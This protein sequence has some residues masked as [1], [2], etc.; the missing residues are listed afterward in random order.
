LTAA[1]PTAAIIY[2]SVGISR[3][4]TAAPAR[5]Q[6]SAVAWCLLAV[7][8][9]AADAATDFLAAFTTEKRTVADGLPQSNVR[10]LS[11]GPDGYL[12]VTT[13]EHMSRFD[14]V[15]FETVPPPAFDP[16]RAPLAG[17]GVGS[18][19]AL[20]LHGYRKVWRHDGRA[21]Q[22]LADEL[23]AG[24]PDSYEDVVRIAHHPDG[25]CW[26]LLR[27]GLVRW[28]PREPQ[29]SWLKP[30]T[31][32][33]TQWN[34]DLVID[35]S[36]RVW[37]ASSSGISRVEGRSLVAVP[38]TA[39]PAGHA[40][41]MRLCRRRAGGIWAYTASGLF[42]VDESG[43][44]LLAPYPG[45]PGAQQIC[46]AS[47]GSVWV[48]GDAGIQR[49]CG[50][51]WSSLQPGTVPGVTRFTTVA[52]SSSRTLW[53]GGDGGL[54][55]LRPR[56]HRLLPVPGGGSSRS[57]L[58][59]AAWHD[60][61]GATLVGTGNRIHQLDPASGVTESLALVPGTHQ[62]GAG[63][64]SALARD[65]DGSLWVGTGNEQLWCLTGDRWRHF[66]ADAGSPVPATG[67]TSILPWPGQL[68]FIGSVNGLMRIT[69]KL[70]MFPAHPSLP[71]DRVQCLV[72]DP[73][74][75][76]IWIGYESHGL[77]F[78]DPSSN[79][80]D[81]APALAGIPPGRVNAVLPQADG[82][83]W[84]SVGDALLWW[85]DGR[86]VARFDHHH[87]LPSGEV[88]LLAADPLGNIWLAEAGRLVCIPSEDL[89]AV[90]AG[91][92]SGVRLRHHGH[93]LP[94]DSSFGT[95]AGHPMS[96]PGVR[97]TV[98]DGII[99]A[100]GDMIPPPAPPPGVRIT[101]I[102]SRGQ[103]LADLSPV[104]PRSP[105]AQPVRVPPGTAPVDIEFTAI[106]AGPPTLQTFRFRIGGVNADWTELG[107]ARRVSIPYLPPGPHQIELALLD[108]NGEWVDAAPATNL[109]VEAWFWQTRWFLGLIGLAGA[110]G[111]FGMTRWFVRRRYHRR[112]RQ[113]ELI[114][115]ERSRIARDIH[116]DLGAG[117]THLA[118]LARIAE[119][120][121]SR[122]LNGEL[123]HHLR[124]VFTEASSMVRS[125]DEI[126]WAVTPAH[127]NLRALVDYLV[128]YA[129]HFL[130]ATDVPCRVDLPP[131][132]PALP[133][134][135]AVR[136]HVYMVVQEALNNVVK[137]ASASEVHFT[138]AL[139]DGHLRLT[140]RD[141]G[142][143]FDPS[144]ASPQDEPGGVC[145]FAERM[146][147]VGG[148][149]ELDSAPGVGTT[150]TFKV[151]LHV[152]T[153]DSIR[154]R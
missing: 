87:G 43:A 25:S 27:G 11:C 132:I 149:F 108:G 144:A 101:R 118:M 2:I 93:G 86:V 142:R 137:H 150:V 111:M 78:F 16:L 153:R 20:W 26:W 116:D 67:I 115:Q 74:R 8:A 69:P 61:S 123:G 42:A 14:G 71:L 117:L 47:D 31:P 105:P 19:G 152:K 154:T 63:V 112:R 54:V 30:E 98:A 89:E 126:V 140:I 66:T 102:S 7:A 135:A 99:E 82:R 77:V 84:I 80:L 131:S 28:H 110:A 58:P 64:I 46:E 120:D 48:A 85:Q 65:H 88:G 4:R 125:V 122:G 21:W 76:G 139:D 107:T 5:W 50:E 56:G 13:S 75:G 124:E 96:G 138:A 136:H 127:D 97:F 15:T 10:D 40:F 146:E 49:W 103:L 83:L 106:D 92:R 18:D 34:R 119:R 145:N 104:F 39:M 109:A 41:A 128:H 53:L 3:T 37:L 17:S 45:A 60:E 57:R 90:A 130:R 24:L 94:D 32:P 143:G 35:D 73:L 114:H 51:R 33:S 151:P 62:P 12:W 44:E 100:H 52:E 72:R 79:R 36:N 6:A 9:A 29:L 55:A 133:V 141:N 38:T 22:S 91:R 129:Q 147:Q 81:P 70:T 148:G 68:P 23:F 121:A 113:E 59:V 134:R 1:T 95:V